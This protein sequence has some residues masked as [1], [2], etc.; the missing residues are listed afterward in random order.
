MNQQNRRWI[1]FSVQGGSILALAGGLTLADPWLGG[2]SGILLIAAVCL[3][4]V[5]STNWLPHLLLVACT[6]GAAL[7]IWMK[8][9]A[10]LMLGGVALALAGWELSETD[11][12][13]NNSKLPLAAEYE[14][15][16][17]LILL[18]VV[19]GSLLFVGIL[20]L[21][22]VTI[23][24]VFLFAAGVVILFSLFRLYRLFKQI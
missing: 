19:M 22:K 6:V 5:K 16:R 12:L 1:F 11:Q 24:F 13:R 4:E 23:P 15:R 8:A 3:Y 17:N 9:P 14:K 10:L 2:I 18:S 20:M 7:G 21:V